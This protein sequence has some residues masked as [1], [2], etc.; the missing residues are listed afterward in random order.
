MKK[1]FEDLKK[2]ITGVDLWVNGLGYLTLG[3]SFEEDGGFNHLPGDD[4]TI[5]HLNEGYNHEILAE[6]LGGNQC[7]LNSFKGKTVILRGKAVEHRQ[8][9]LISFDDG[10]TWFDINEMKAELDKKWHKYH[11]KK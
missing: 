5:T 10:K 2:T 1:Q 9:G 8:N 6:L 11:D 7:S 3:F 4:W